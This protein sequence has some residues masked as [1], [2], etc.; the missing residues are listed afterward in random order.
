MINLSRQRNAD[1]NAFFSPF[2]VYATGHF[3]CY[4]FGTCFAAVKLLKMRGGFLAARLIIVPVQNTRLCGALQN[5][6]LQLQSGQCSW[7][8][9]LCLPGQQTCT[10]PCGNS[11]LHTCTYMCT[12]FDC[13][14]GK[15]YWHGGII[16][17]WQLMMM[18]DWL[19]LPR[20]ACV[21]N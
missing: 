4:R 17:C 9:S 8:A 16:W 6:G 7:A 5:V 2:L 10:L 1:F 11:S 12:D 19:K 14:A 21:S 15:E 18:G 13:S 20:G 3:C